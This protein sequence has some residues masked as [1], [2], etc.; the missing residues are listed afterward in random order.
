MNRRFVAAQTSIALIVALFAARWQVAARSQGGVPEAK[1]DALFARWNA[2]TTPG[3][4]V[5]AS[6]GGKI[7]LAKAYGMADLEH[8]VRNTPDT[9]FEAGSVSKQFTAAAVLLLAREGKLSLDDPARKYIP[10]LPEYPS[11]LLVRQMLQH[12]SGLRDWGNVAGIAGWPRTSRVHTHAHVLDIVRRQRALNFE[13]GT[14]WSYSNTGYNLAAIIVS[15]VSGEPF[16]EFTKKRI[17]QPLGMTHTSWRDDYTRIVKHRAIA[18]ADT[19]ETYRM[20]MPFE[21]VHG[22]GGLLTTVDDLLRWNENFVEPKV[23]DADFLR[24][25]QRPGRFKNGQQ[26]DYGL[27]LYIRTYKGLREVGHS[28]STAGYRAYLVRYPDQRVSVAVLCNVTTGTAE[29]FA[30]DVADLYLAGNLKPAAAS[31][32]ALLSAAELDARVGLYRSLK[33]GEPMTISRD[34][35]ANQLRADANQILTALSPSRFRMGTGDSILEVQTRPDGTVS[36][37]RVVRPNGT[38]EEFDR[39]VTAQPTPHQLQELAGV[40]ASDDAETTF[41]VAVS[42]GSLQLKRRPDTTLTL[43]PLYTDA[44]STSSLGTIRFHRDRQGRVIE[45]SVIMDRVWDMRFRREAET[46]TSQ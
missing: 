19:R 10:E 17:F 34:A 2:Q 37:A 1:V 23:G 45:L 24:E 6:V 30:H 39:V 3:C 44:F 35:D 33:T 46:T 4:A 15:R 29:R 7:V 27:G 22:N 11:P 25:Q 40:Y 26:H 31:A 21:N 20:E 32:V 41:T 14:D 18:Y 36:G 13:P 8:D 16:A 28:G 12:T 38:S 42:G 5:G 9:I 43:R